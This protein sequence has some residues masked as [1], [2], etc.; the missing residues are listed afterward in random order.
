[1]GWRK[2]RGEGVLG[3]GSFEGVAR[4]VGGC[5]KRGRRVGYRWERVDGRTW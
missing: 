5:W 1:M 3:R 2:G 4:S